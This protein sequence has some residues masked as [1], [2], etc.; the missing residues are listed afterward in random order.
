MK[1]RPPHLPGAFA[2]CVSHNTLRNEKWNAAILRV[3]D[4]MSRRFDFP[5]WPLVTAGLECHFVYIWLIHDS[6]MTLAL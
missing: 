6:V 2:V 1:A 4:E 5:L 3:V